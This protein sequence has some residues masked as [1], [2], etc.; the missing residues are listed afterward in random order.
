MRIQSDFNK[1]GKTKVRSPTE[2]DQFFVPFQAYNLPSQFV[3][4]ILLQAQLL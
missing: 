4:T 3:T 1:I 2:S